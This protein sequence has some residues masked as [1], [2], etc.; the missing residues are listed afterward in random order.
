MGGWTWTEVLHPD[1]ADRARLAWQH[2]A[3]TGGEYEVEFR[4]RRHDGVYRWHRSRGSPMQDERGRITRWF[5]TCTDIDDRKRDEVRLREAEALY[6]QIV[7]TANDGI[8]ICDLDQRTT[9]VNPTMAEMLGYRPEEMIG[10][11]AWDFTFAEERDEGQRRWEQRRGGAKGRGEFRLRRRDGSEV[12]MRSSTTPMLDANGRFVGRRGCSPTSPR[13]AAP[14]KNAGRRDAAAAGPRGGPDGHLGLGSPRRARCL[15]GWSGAGPRPAVGRLR[16]DDGGL[17]S[18]GPS[19]GPRAGGGGDRRALEEAAGYEAEF[20]IVHPDGSVA[21]I[22]SKGLAF[23]DASGR[24]TRMAGVGMDI[25]ERKRAEEA[26]RQSEQRFA[27]FMQHLPGLAWIK[28]ARGRYVYAN[29]DAVRAFGVPRETLYGGP[30]RRSSRPRPPPQFRGTTA[31][32][33]KT[34]AGIRAIETLVHPDGTAHHSL[35]SKFPVPSPEGDNVLVGGMAIDITDRMEMEEALKEADRRKDEFLATLA[36]ELRNPLAPIRN[37]LQVMRLAG[38]DR[39]TAEQARTMM[40]RQMQHLVRLVDDLLDVSRISR[41]KIELRKER[42]ELAAV[43]ASARGGDRPI[44][45]AGGPRAD[46]DAAGGPGARGRRPDPAGP[47]RLQPAEQRRQVQRPGGR[48]RLTVERQGDEAVV[49]VRDTGI[50]IPAP[51]LP[52][53]LRHVHAGGSLAG[54]V[55]RRA[56]HRPDHREAAGGDA[57]RRHRGPQ[58]RPRHGERV[59]RPPAR[60]RRPSGPPGRKGGDEPRPGSPPRH[61]ILV[62]DDNEDAARS[63]A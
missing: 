33:S 62:V 18:A 24:A 41:G 30:T 8:W 34:G 54:E 6:R 4:L 58:R 5:G 36:H 44:D 43:V 17:R 23:A 29:D 19:R 39:E 50:G 25:T 15:V 26:L 51:M 47:G 48:I 11:S 10:K 27:R 14:R 59:H 37:G 63:L 49:S 55:A 9:F 60:R 3:A 31:G 46:G 52:Q 53:G 13:P 56:G 12:W 1:D 20:R 38:H 2:A 40:E 21:W 45:P 57:R 16:R 42:V 28:D 61:R 32:R 35:V 7:E 22:L